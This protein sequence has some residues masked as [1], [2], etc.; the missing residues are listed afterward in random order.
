MKK[1]IKIYSI[2]Q[3]D[4]FLYQLTE[5]VRAGIYVTHN[6]MPF[7]DLYKSLLNETAKQEHVEVFISS[8]LEEV[9]T[10]PTCQKKADGFSM[11]IYNQNTIHSWID[12]GYPFCNKHGLE[13]V[14]FL[15]FRMRSWGGD[16]V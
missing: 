5:H 15:N 16:D 9:C 11:T 14:A 7:L 6:P 12:T 3:T 4:T 8:T 2:K 1:Y 13:H 10:N